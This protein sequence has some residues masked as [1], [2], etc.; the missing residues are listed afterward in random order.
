MLTRKITNAG[1]PIINPD[2]TPLSNV[3]IKFILVGEDGQPVD[4]FDATSKEQV[5]GLVTV[6]TDENGEFEVDLYPNQN[7]DKISQY[8]VKFYT[9]Y[10]QDFTAV[11]EAGDYSDLSFVDFKMLGVAITP[12]QID[13]LEEY[14]ADITEYVEANAVAGPAGPQGSQ[15]VQGVPGPNGYQI[16]NAAS[17]TYNIDGTINTFVE[18]G[19]T[20]TFTYNIDGSTNTITDGT[21]TLTIN[22]NIDGSI[23]TVTKGA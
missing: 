1:Q 8:H 22:Y 13:M 4:V 2:G 7:G 12:E 6:K 14:L 18:D 5:V 21:D 19:K 23:N 10:V 15:G 11:L 16:L 9:D 20:Y 17:V 3:T